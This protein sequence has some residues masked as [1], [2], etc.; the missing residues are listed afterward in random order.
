[1]QKKVFIPYRKS[2]K[3]INNNNNNTHDTP[4]IVTFSFLQ[5]KI[6][7]GQLGKFNL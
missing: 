5:D 2:E 4:K 3:I 6:E 7:D 1:M